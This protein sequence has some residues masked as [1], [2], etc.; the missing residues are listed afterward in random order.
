MNNQ[1]KKP[2]HNAGE[3]S[4]AAAEKKAKKR[5]TVKASANRPFTTATPRKRGGQMKYESPEL[6]EAAIDAYF[7]DPDC[8]FTMCG[9]A[10]ALDFCERKSLYDYA[11]RPGFDT[12]VKKALTRI[13]QRHE[14]QSGH[15][16]QAV[17][18]HGD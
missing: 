2:T 15:A 6:F 10:L 14:R 11:K 9:L 1:P 3:K 5:K 18:P 17:Q 16:Q 13:E 7:D 8:D 12:H 4:P